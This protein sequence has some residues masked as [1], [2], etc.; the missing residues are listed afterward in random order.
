MK[1][2]KYILSAIVLST[3]FFGCDDNDLAGTIDESAKPKV[4]FAISSSSALEIDAP[5]IIISISMDRPIKSTT[6]FS[7]TQ[8]S[9]GA[10]LH[11][12]YEVSGGVIP[13]FQTEGEIVISVI[14]DLDV[15]GNETADFQVGAASIPDLYEVI[16]TADINLTIE[17][18]VFCAWTL[19][20]VDTYGDSWN[21]AAI[22]VTSG[23]EVIDYANDGETGTEVLIFDL[24]SSDICLS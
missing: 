12:D 6:T 23:G 24:L 7:A 20:A 16:G 19:D 18:Y 4:T 15:E 10:E 14:K 11:E 13:A 1:K 8:V 22:R 5:E 2:I 21:G 9:G 3:A 17:D